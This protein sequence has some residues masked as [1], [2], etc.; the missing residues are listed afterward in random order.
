[1]RSAPAISQ[2]LAVR[3]IL[4]LLNLH[5][6]SAPTLVAWVVAWSPHY[7]GRISGICDIVRSR[8]LTKVLACLRRLRKLDSTSV[9]HWSASRHGVN[10][11]CRHMP[12]Q[13][14]RERSIFPQALHFPRFLEAQPANNPRVHVRG[15]CLLCCPHISTYQY[16]PCW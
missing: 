15:S 5:L 6:D 9:M 14:K 13:V 1:M 8:C 12:Y 4:Q 16:S 7:H 3:K 11:G 10:V 2:C